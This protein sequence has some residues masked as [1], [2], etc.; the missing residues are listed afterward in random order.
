MNTTDNIGVNREFKDRLFRLL[1]C[2]KE[3]ALELYNGLNH[4]HYT[5]ADELEIVTLEDAIWMKMKNDVAY[6]IRDVLALF[7]HQSTI[8]SNLPLRG[9]LYFADMFRGIVKDKNIYGTKLIQ[10]PT[11]VYVVFYN[12]DKDI[13]E[14]T[15]LKLSDAFVHGNKQSKMEL[16]VQVLNINYGHNKRLMDDC[17]TLRHYAILVD[18]IK[19]YRKNM[20]LS[21]AVSKAIDECIEEGV[22]QDF[23]KRRRAEV[24][25][26]ILTEYDEKRVLED[27]GQEKYEEGMEIGWTFGMEATILVLNNV[28][29]G[30]SE[31]QI[32]EELAE[33]FSLKYEDAKRYYDMCLKLR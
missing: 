3:N 13:G 21:A 29:E 28:E 9:F 18:K 22:L 19:T 27:I 10:L 2:D 31:E 30:K 4:S 15:S 33:R 32:L 12:G 6:L 11:P 7:E 24:M 1:Y 16:Q 26:S 8:N 5:N 14:K 20:E 25:N 17:P 23:L